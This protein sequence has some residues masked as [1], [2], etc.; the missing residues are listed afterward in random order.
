MNEVLKK[1]SGIGIVPVIKIEDIEN[2]VPLAKALIDGGLPI[3]EIT[4]RA[5]GADKAIKAIKEAFPQMVVGAGTV[6]TIDQVKAAKD[7]GAEFIV[8][9]GF[10][11]KTV[12]YCNEIGMPITPG[13]TTASEIELAIEMGLEVVKFFPAEQSG[14]L[15]KIKSLAGPFA[16]MK[17]IPTGGIDLKNLSTYLSFDKIIACGGSFM[18]KEEFIKNK[19]WD[20]ITALSRQ[21][22]D[23]MLG[24]EIA[25]VGINAAN[26][27]EA[28]SVA[29]MFGMLFNML[30]KNGNSSIFA[31][32]AVEVMKAPFLGKNGHI[33]I[34][35]YSIPRA[36]AHL[37][38]R[39]IKFNENSVKL[40]AK[41]KIAA[42]YLEQEIAGFAVHLAQ[43]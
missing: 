40:D 39:G 2:A 43:K 30:V 13:C 24:F 42:I 22:V 10:N 23:I 29:N 16:N 25:H 15:D 14:G 38:S 19:E 37:E 3:A 34:K 11:P 26:E 21:A 41:G 4:F 8:S 17:F 7:A 1:I 31:G 33:G 9:P 18:V 28:L 36:K 12:A 20:K 27:E 32:T 6:L 35:T 5:A